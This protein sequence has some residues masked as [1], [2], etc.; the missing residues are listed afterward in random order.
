MTLCGVE[1]SPNG[2]DAAGTLGVDGVGVDLVRA[3]DDEPHDE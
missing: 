2:C 1:Y 3:L